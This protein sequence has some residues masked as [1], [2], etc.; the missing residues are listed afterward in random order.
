MNEGYKIVPNNAIT[1][2][3]TSGI[4]IDCEEEIK[5]YMRITYE[6]VTYWFDEKQKKLKFK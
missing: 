2:F 3:W 1:A 6:G 5:P 4:L